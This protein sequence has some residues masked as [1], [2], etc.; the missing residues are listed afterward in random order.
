MSAS[1]DP[2][3]KLRLG[4]PSSIKYA[5]ALKTSSSNWNYSFKIEAL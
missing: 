4:F 5:S 1:T 2:I 3:D